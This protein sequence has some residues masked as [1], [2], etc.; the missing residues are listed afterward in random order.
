MRQE[1]RSHSSHWGA[2]SAREGADGLEVAARPGDPDPPALHANLPAAVRHRSRVRRPAVRRG[3]LE[4]GPGPAQRGTEEFVEISWD[5]AIELVGDELGRVYRDAGAHHVYG[6]SY[7]WAS[8]GRFHHAQS[9]L[10][11]FLNVLGGYVSSRNTYSLGA[12]EVLL[13][14]LVGADVGTGGLASSWS[15]VAAHT[16]LL[17]SFGGLPLKNAAVSPGGM[18]EHVVAGRLREVLDRGGELVLVGPV[19]NLPID[20]P[21]VRW[22]PIRP[23]TDVAVMLAMSHVL[24]AEDLTDPGVLGELCEGAPE[25]AEYVLAGR[26]GAGFDPAWAESVSGVPAAEIAVVARRLA[27]ERSLVNVSWALQR[28]RHGEQPIWAGLALACLAGG[29]GRPGEGFGLGYASMSEIGARKLD[30]GVP[31][32][33]QG[34]NP[35]PDFIPVAAVSEMLLRPGEEFDYDGQRLRFPEISLVY[36]AGGN[37]FHHHQDLGRLRR[38]FAAPETVI[39]HECFWTAT[40]RHADIVLPST[41]SLER[42]DL[43]ASRVDRNLIAMQRVLEPYAEAR[44][45][46]A[47]FGDLAAHLGVGAAF[48]EGRTPEEWLRHLYEGW[49]RGDPR[50]AESLPGFDVFWRDGEARLP[51]PTTELSRIEEFRADPVGR[52]LETP[53]GRIELVSTTIAGFGYHDC[54]GHP[55]WFPPDVLDGELTARHPLCLLADQPAGRLHSQLDMSAHSQETKTGGRE[56]LHLSETDARERGIVDGDQVVLTSP[57]GECLAVARVDPAIA[58]GAARLSTGAWYDPEDLAAGRERCVHGNPNVLTLDR[59]TSSLAQ[60]CTGARVLVQVRRLEEAPR[61]PTPYH[62]PSLATATRTETG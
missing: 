20:H 58:P 14:H 31:R 29:I 37:P 5:A 61:P 21:R 41:M 38:A 54:P 43:G 59:G 32:L 28:A 45:D 2:F 44:D 3:W 13:P 19:R 10:H 30:T 34:D 55:T 7:G 56:P 24:L 62:P 1:W 22:L 17:V 26:D 42:D 40:A 6:G 39:V 57:V 52:A 16:E 18:S 60:G 25:F 51:E 33:P 48:T 27:A 23:G 8:A 4:N 53:S 46:Y 47:I 12:A 9:Q 36:W 11:R 49:R 15:S 50:L 35:V